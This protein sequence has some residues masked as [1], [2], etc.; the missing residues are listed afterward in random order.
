MYVLKYKMTIKNLVE[1]KRVGSDLIRPLRHSELRKGQDF[2][3]T[4]YDKDNENETIHIACLSQNN[5]I[6]C[7]TFYPEFTHKLKT[8]NP[9][10]LRGMAT[11]TDFTRRGHGTMLMK[12]AFKLLQKKDVDIIWCNARLGALNFYKKLG[13]EVLGDIFN[14]KDIGPHYYMFKKI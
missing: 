4:C 6:S 11:A 9:Y 3:T 10:R 5:V 14:I 1:I 13:F 2:T 12:K 7:A 8:E